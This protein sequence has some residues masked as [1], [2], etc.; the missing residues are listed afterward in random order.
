M[1]VPTTTT[2]T[3]R[4]IFEWN[5]PIATFM[6]SLMVIIMQVLNPLIICGVIRCAS[7]ARENN[8]D[9]KHDD[10]LQIRHRNVQSSRRVWVSL[11]KVIL[12][13]KKSTMPL[14]PVNSVGSTKITTDNRV[15]SRSGRRRAKTSSG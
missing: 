15:K 13:R 8:A 14:L 7:T 4:Y 1:S 9:Q 10:E 3:P 6:I 11:D 12:S 5:E 2:A